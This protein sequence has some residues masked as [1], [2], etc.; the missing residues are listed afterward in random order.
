MRRVKWV[1]TFMPFHVEQQRN[2]GALW[3]KGLLFTGLELTS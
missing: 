2:N 1:T 3:L